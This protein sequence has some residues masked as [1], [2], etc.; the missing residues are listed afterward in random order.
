MCGNS[1]S[2]IAYL[3]MAKPPARV[4]L[5]ALVDL[6]CRDGVDVRPTLLRVTTDLYVQKPIHDADEEA[7]YVALALGLIDSVDAA[8]RSAVAATLAGYPA[9]PAAVLL[10]LAGVRRQQRAPERREPQRYEP[11]REPPRQEPELSQQVRNDLVDLFF[12]ANAEER[13]LILRNLDI[14]PRRPPLFV[15]GELLR[16]LERAAL[17][18]D[19]GEFGRV[20][21]RALEVGADLADRIARDNSGEPV[22]VAAKALGMTG[23]VL[24]RILLFLNPVIGQSSVRIYEL[25]KLFDDITTGAALRMVTIWQTGASP[26]II[27]RAL[28]A[29]QLPAAPRTS[30][31]PSAHPSAH[32]AGQAR[33][34]ASRARST[35]HEPVYWDDERPAAR[36]P[37]TPT[38]RTPDRAPAE[39]PL[40]VSRNLKT[41]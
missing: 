15:A 8:T 35:T 36:A 37:A 39:R 12:S 41:K 33:V 17:S 25:S 6:A 24:A 34:H 2:P 29:E 14:D 31:H 4:P 18:R 27:E 38:E 32:A 10:R 20:L 22:V 11:L 13:R 21:A 19:A 1:A 16:R 26:A 40:P 28:E 3:S 5:D 7:Q 23:E 9:A 30:A